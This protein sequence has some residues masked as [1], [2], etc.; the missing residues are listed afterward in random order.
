MAHNH[1][2]AKFSGCLA[3]V[4]GLNRS[5]TNKTG[6]IA[7][8][9]QLYQSTH[10]TKGVRDNKPFNFYTAGGCFLCCTSGSSTE[11]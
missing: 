3:T 8:A 5:G 7:S 11:Q 6:D 4:G 9:M 10:V 2:V 1:D